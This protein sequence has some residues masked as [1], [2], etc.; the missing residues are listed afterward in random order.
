MTHYSAGQA[1]DSLGFGRFQIYL[2]VMVGFAY[3][4]DAMEMMI[5]SILGPALHC[6]W[7]ISEYQQAT[8]TT[9][10][11]LGM[12]LSSSLWGILADKYGRRTVLVVSISF[13]FY[14]A[15]LSAAAPSFGWMLFLRYLV[16]FYIG[17]VPQV[18]A[19]IG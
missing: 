9:V 2:S 13:L 5:L 4:A 18:C 16:G 14:F 10:V 7:H 15:V 6:E 17:G 12:L 19:Y 8:L 3:M 1:I 11:F